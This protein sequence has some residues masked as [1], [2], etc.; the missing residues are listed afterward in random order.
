MEVED[1]E[2]EA[3][4]E[5]EA[6]AEQIP[7]E[8]ETEFDA[9]LEAESGLP[10]FKIKIA[11]SPLPDDL[12]ECL[13]WIEV[14]QSISLIAQAVIAFDNPN[15]KTSDRSELAMGSEI[16]IEGGF[17]GEVG[18][19]FKGDIISLEPNFPAGGGNPG[20]ARGGQQSGEGLAETAGGSGH[21]RHP[22]EAEEIELARGH[23]EPK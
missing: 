8:P 4:L 21:Y 19:L 2:P 7:P 22:F 14:E 18:A 5:L 20:H 17:V 6:I 11:G 12:L 10:D 23:R 13:K 3:E 9:E 16:E 15:G 1:E